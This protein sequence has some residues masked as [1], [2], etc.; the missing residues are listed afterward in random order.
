[1]LYVDDGAGSSSSPLFAPPCSQPP[2]QQQQ[3][4][5]QRHRQ[6]HGQQ[7]EHP[8]PREVGEAEEQQSRSPD[9][10]PDEG[11]MEGGEEEE[12]R[13]FGGG[14]IV[15]VSRDPFEVWG[16][17]RLGLGSGPG[18]SATGSVF[19][20]GS[21]SLHEAYTG[22]LLAIFE[23]FDVGTGV[24][25]S[26]DHMRQI[27]RK[28]FWFRHPDTGEIMTEWE[29]KAVRPIVYD[30]QV[31]DYHRGSSGGV[32]GGGDG[33]ITYSVEAS[34]RRLKGALPPMKITSRSAGPDQMMINVPVFLDVPVP[35]S[36]GGGRY[37]AWEFYDYVVDP[38]FPPGRPPTAVWCRQGSV[39][40]FF[41]AD[42]PSAVLRFS[43]HR[44]DSY[45]ELPARMRAEVEARH[46]HFRG[47]PADAEEA[48]RLA[49][50]PG[51]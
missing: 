35:E 32:G 11:G 17:M 27:S 1:M 51:R 20:V 7:E 50:G 2:Q 29:G 45:E 10:R 15:D 36:V 44:V 49:E 42:D 12:D 43:G 4:Q 21:G 28:I 40:P 39:P 38:S 48:T 26:D 31:I 24:R 6:R 46:P 9:Q 22:K 23:G 41:D 25:M 34:L 33:S 3:Q 19:W 37:R 18:S 16:K 8:Q 30:A 5:P 14:A 13:V 47:P